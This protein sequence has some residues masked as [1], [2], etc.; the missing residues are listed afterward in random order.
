MTRLKFIE[1]ISV[2]LATNG[3]LSILSMVI[4]F[5][6]LVLT[7]VIPFQMVWGGRLSERQEMFVFEAISILLNALMLLA[8]GLHTGLFRL[9]V[10]RKITTV[11]LWLM[12]ILFL[13]NTVGNL[14]SNNRTE[15]IIFTP[16]TLILGLLSLRLAVAGSKA[17]VSE[18]NKR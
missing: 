11:A 8:V 1:L 9:S 7:G 17:E 15:M 3:L 18:E 4:V 10:N 13:V 16:L 14:F 12:V 6:V 2:R 5:H